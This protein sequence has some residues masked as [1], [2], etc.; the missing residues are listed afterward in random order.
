MGYI[1]GRVVGVIG[2]KQK[3]LPPSNFFLLRHHKKFQPSSSKRS[4]VIHERSLPRDRQTDRQTTSAMLNYSPP[5]N[6]KFRRGQKGPCPSQAKERSKVGMRHLLS[7]SVISKR[8][9]L[10]LTIVMEQK[11]ST[12]QVPLRKRL[13]GILRE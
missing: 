6:C 9:I 11:L 1:G 3:N 5:Q 12:D 10:R 4:K 13:L 7:I 8:A 2:S